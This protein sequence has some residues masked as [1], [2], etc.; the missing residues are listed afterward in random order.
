MGH[1]FPAKR[2]FFM[3]LKGYRSQCLGVNPPKK[4][5]VILVPGIMLSFR[6]CPLPV[7]VESEG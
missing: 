6:C 4:T 2:W 7:L 1:E 5:K 3:T